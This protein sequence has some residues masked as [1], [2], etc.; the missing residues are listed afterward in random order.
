MNH[1]W[2]REWRNHAV[3][4]KHGKVF[5]KTN[6]KR[7]QHTLQKALSDRKT[8]IIKRAEQIFKAKIGE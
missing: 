7:P 8:A 5:Y 1:L 2:K 3:H 4:G 6:G